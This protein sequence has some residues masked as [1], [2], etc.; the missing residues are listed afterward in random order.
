VGGTRVKL[1][2][3]ARPDFCSTRLGPPT[4]ARKT[5]PTQPQAASPFPSWVVEL[6]P[7]AL[8]QNP[9]SLE[10]AQNTGGEFCAPS[11]ISGEFARPSPLSLRPPSALHFPDDNRIT[12]HLERIMSHPRGEIPTISPHRHARTHV[13]QT[14][15]ACR[16]G[17]NEP[18][19]APPKKGKNLLGRNS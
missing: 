8:V 1:K 5:R 10:G 7:K 14:T 19:N 16:V 18:N 4:I 3:F 11:Q 13:R 17:R 6:F 12:P 2:T 9:S 15:C